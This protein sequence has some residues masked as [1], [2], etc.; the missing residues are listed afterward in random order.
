MVEWA[1]PHHAIIRCAMCT[2]LLGNFYFLAHHATG[3]EQP[4]ANLWAFYVNLWA[5]N[6]KIKCK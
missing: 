1:S 3:Q 6:E 2:C 4:I 5:S